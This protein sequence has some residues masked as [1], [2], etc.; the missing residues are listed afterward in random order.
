MSKPYMHTHGVHGCKGGAFNQI[1][2]SWLI[3]LRHY[4]IWLGRGVIVSWRF[5]TTSTLSR[6]ILLY[7]CAL[8]SACMHY[9]VRACVHSFKLTCFSNAAGTSRRSSMR[10]L[11]MR[12]RR[13]FSIIC[14][15]RER[16]REGGE[17]GKQR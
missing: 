9:S 17:G 15:A 14:I 11:F 13:L 6:L 3:S 8:H 16:E 5:N 4:A 10:Q 12:S 2:P 1:K 7:L